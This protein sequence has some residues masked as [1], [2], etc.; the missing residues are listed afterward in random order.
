[1]SIQRDVS[2]KNFATIPVIPSMGLAVATL[3]IFCPTAGFA[4][5]DPV[6]SVRTDTQGTT[7]TLQHGALRLDAFAPRVIHVQYSATGKFAPQR[8]PTVIARP[9]PPKFHVEEAG[10]SVTLI[11][12][13]VQARVDRK[14][15]SVTFLNSAG[16]LILAEE[17]GGRTLEPIVL[18]GPTPANAFKSKHESG[19]HPLDDGPHQPR[20]YRAAFS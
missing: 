14:T 15:G 6:A 17:Q 11:T 12:P 19:V 3:A 4:D 8:V 13:D 1:M 16:K 5:P 9:A 18:A 10:D 2:M 20:R 7:L